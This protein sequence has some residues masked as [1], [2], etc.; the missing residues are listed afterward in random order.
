MRWLRWF[1]DFQGDEIPK[2]AWELSPDWEDLH[3]N[4]DE[5]EVEA[6]VEKVRAWRKAEEA[7]EEKA[8]EAARSEATRA[9][10]N[11]MADTTTDDLIYKGTET[12]QRVIQKGKAAGFD[13]DDLQELMERNRES[14]DLTR[15]LKEEQDMIL[16]GSRR[17]SATHQRMKKVMEDA[18]LPHAFG[19]RSADGEA[20]DKEKLKAAR[21]AA[22]KA[23]E[24]R[25]A[26][27]D[28][29]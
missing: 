3:P 6:S 11:E 16:G 13:V 10:L 19:E 1:G 26:P 14:N 27:H 2:H 22:M 12:L 23:E 15:R 17:L 24:A 21:A 20:I 18:G 4:A 7:R 5:E 9:F 28:E 25:E 8:R 29:L